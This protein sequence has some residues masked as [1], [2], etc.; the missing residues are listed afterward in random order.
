[1]ALKGDYN[2]VQGGDDLSFYMNET[3]ERGIIVVHSTTGSGAALDQADAVV[4]IPTGTASGTKPAGLL[5]CDVV[6][7]D[8][9]RQ[10]LNEHKF[11]VQKNSKVLLAK[12]GWVVTDRIVTGVSPVAG[13]PAYYDVNGKFRITDTGGLT[14][15]G[16]FLSKK[17]DD[18]YA[19]V[20]INIV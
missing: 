13:S 18:G 19:K 12:Q 10:H 3:G 17:D 16:R 4:T 20:Y 1:M 2:I 6:D 15:V 11:E 7:Y 5:M 8:L 9:T 14:Q